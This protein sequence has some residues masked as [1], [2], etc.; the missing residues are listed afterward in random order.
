[1]GDTAGRIWFASCAEG[2]T[3][4]KPALYLFDPATGSL[5]KIN[6]EH[7][8]LA[9]SNAMV[10]SPDA[11]KF[12]LGCSIDGGVWQYDCDLDAK[13]PQKILSGGKEV[14]RL[15]KPFVPD[16]SKWSRPLVV[17]EC[18]AYDMPA[19]TCDSKGRLYLAVFNGYASTCF[20]RSSRCS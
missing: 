2:E 16:G 12:Y 18:R 4:I 6:L 7:Q 14:I 13:D 1:M 11:K 19:V 15:E 20:L 3:S 5:E 8:E 17:F 9:M 10:F